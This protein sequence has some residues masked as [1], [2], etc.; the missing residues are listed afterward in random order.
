MA[1]LILYRSPTPSQMKMTL[2]CAWLFSTHVVDL[3]VGDTIL[4]TDKG[5]PLWNIRVVPG[6]EAKTPTYALFAKATGQQLT[7]KPV[8]GSACQQNP[9]PTGSTL[10]AM[11]AMPSKDDLITRRS[12]LSLALKGSLAGSVLIG[13]GM[14]VRFISYQSEQSPPSQYDLGQAS[15][16]P[17]GSRITVPTAQA[18]I[19]HDSQGIHAISLVC[20]HLGCLVNVTSDG[21]ACPCHGSRFSPDGSLRNGPA[22]RPLTALRVE[23]NPEG[24][25]IL[26]TS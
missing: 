10:P 24:H 1:R 15:D 8:M 9:R 7:F 26:Y 12:F 4:V 20:P 22:S 16:F 17:L 6:D 5:D 25:L 18:I 11:N 23:E 3:K 2:P 21:F 19:I 14:M 13:L